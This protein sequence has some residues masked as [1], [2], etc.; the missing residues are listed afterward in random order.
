MSLPWLILAAGF[1]V[2]ELLVAH[3]TFEGQAHTVDLSA[4]PLLVG[5]VFCSPYD[6]LAAR[7]LGLALVLVIH[8]RQRPIKLAF[9][10]SMFALETCVAVTTFRALA[11]SHASIGPKAWLPALIACALE[12]VVGVLGVTLA[13]LA[14]SG[15]IT[16]RALSGL[17]LEGAVLGPVAN[18]SLGLCV[19]VLLWFE[20][21]AAVL[22]LPIMAVLVAAY[23]GYM[24]LKQRYAN[25][26]K[27]Y[28]F[29]KRTQH[30]GDIDSVASTVLEAARSVM[31]AEIGHLVV[32]TDCRTAAL[33]VTVDTSGT[34]ATRAPFPSPSS[35]HCGSAPRSPL[36]AC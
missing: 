12:N 28:E 27:L 15:H 13:I 3:V 35:G 21:L 29:N 6:L 19:T 20:P 16:S 24:S 31:N 22:M 34:V 5:L 23:R 26:D 2:S 25:L 30:R 18:S 7:L 17:L 9:N 33:V 10:L 1:V 36:P 4:V 11:G 8:R 32:L 14:T